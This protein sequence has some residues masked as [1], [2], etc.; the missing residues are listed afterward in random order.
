MTLPKPETGLAH[1]VQVLGIGVWA[2]L[3][4]SR[5]LV[6]SHRPGRET[7]LDRR[8]GAM[9]GDGRTGG[10][11][12]GPLLLKIALAVCVVGF[13]IN[14]VEHLERGVHYNRSLIVVGVLSL[15]ILALGSG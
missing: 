5:L 14:L 10:D 1:F 7:F 6:W 15:L 2:L 8:W 13:L 3:L 11:A 9:V 4:G 12:A